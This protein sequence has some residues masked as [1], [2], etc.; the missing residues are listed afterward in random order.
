[1]TDDEDGNQLTWTQ[2]KETYTNVFDSELAEFN[3]KLH[4]YTGK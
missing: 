2:L 1:M 4:E 3:K